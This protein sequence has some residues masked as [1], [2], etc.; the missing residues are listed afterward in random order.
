L[1]FDGHG[2]C[3]GLNLVGMRRAGIAAS[4]R[5]EL[6]AAYRR[7]YRTPGSL[8]SALADLSAMMA[9]PA[10]MRFLDFLQGNSKRGIHGHSMQ[11]AAA[12]LPLNA[13]T[14]NVA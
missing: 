8:S 13:P 5:A 4:D 2:V 3:V 10:G 6:K 11:D 9:S 14:V 12:T 1:M 7:L